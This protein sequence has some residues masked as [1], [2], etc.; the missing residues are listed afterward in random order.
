MSITQSTAGAGGGDLWCMHIEG[1]DDLHAAPDFWT[2]LAWAAELNTFIAEKAI[3]GGW[4]ADDN[5]PL[6]QAT[7]RR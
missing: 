2:A 6:S 4:A 5:Y 1:P 7:V 3:K